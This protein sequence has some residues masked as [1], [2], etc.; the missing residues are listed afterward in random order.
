[1]YRFRRKLLQVIPTG[2]SLVPVRRS[3]LPIISPSKGNFR[4]HT[5]ATPLAALRV[6]LALATR[7]GWAAPPRAPS[8]SRKAV[9]IPGLRSVSLP[10]T[11]FGLTTLKGCPHRF[12]KVVVVVV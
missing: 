5:R 6:S 10:P 12:K 8:T 3:G 9:I 4:A 2:L 11:P 7:G 1:M